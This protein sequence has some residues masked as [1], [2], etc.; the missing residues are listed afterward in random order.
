MSVA[1]DPP[2]PVLV[3]AVVAPTE[4]NA[5]VAAVH[6][7]VESTHAAGFDLRLRLSFRPS[8]ATVDTRDPRSIIIVSLLPDLFAD[9]AWSQ[10]HGRWRAQATPLAADGAPPVFLC[11]I[12]RH[13]GAAPGNPAIERLRR[14]NLLATELSRDF[15]F[16]IVDIDRIFAHFGAR[17][18][19]TD[20]RLTGPVAAEVAGYAIVDAVLASTLDHLIPPEVQE[21][22]QKFQGPLEAMRGLVSRRL[23]QRQKGAANG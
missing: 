11:T 18:L 8:V 3:M 2:A 6:Q 19:V 9:E 5:V 13:I 1:A 14:L 16:N 23:R 7:L 12:F 21:E 15:G 10:T 22:A 17:E 4:R 20:C